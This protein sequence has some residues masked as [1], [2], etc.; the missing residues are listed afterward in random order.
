MNWTVDD[1]GTGSFNTGPGDDVS[2]G[3]KYIY[4][5]TSGVNNKIGNVNSWY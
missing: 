5:E 2:G 4:T 1:F 3:G